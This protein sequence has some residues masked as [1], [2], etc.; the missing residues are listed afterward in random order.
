VLDFLVFLQIA[1]D[2]RERW[3]TSDSPVVH[4]IQEYVPLLTVSR[5]D[6]TSSHPF[7]NL[8]KLVLQ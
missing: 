2:L 7:S 6:L 5:V 8:M 3:E 1:E 4:R